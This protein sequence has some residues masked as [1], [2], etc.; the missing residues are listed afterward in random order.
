MGFS[1]KRGAGDIEGQRSGIGQKFYLVPI[2]G[3]IHQHIFPGAD[4]QD[5]LLN[6]IRYGADGKG[7]YFL[8]V[9][10]YIRSAVGVVGV[11]DRPA[12]QWLLFS[13]P[14]VQ[15]QD[16]LT[17]V[18]FQKL[19]QFRPQGR[20]LIR[21]KG[22]VDSWKHAPGNRS[23]NAGFHGSGSEAQFSAQRDADDGDLVGIVIV[24]DGLYR[25]FPLVCK[26]QS[27]ST[28]SGSLSRAFKSQHFVSG[29]GQIQQHIGE[30]FQQGIISAVK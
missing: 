25:F 2:E 22:I 1:K 19:L 28:E 21:H 16:F 23:R 12:K 15:L 9:F 26:G 29:A 11:A 4:Q 10:I 27:I 8:Q 17:P 5:I 3:K 13:Q 7:P 30:F 6:L 24:Q 18:F 20:R 14:P